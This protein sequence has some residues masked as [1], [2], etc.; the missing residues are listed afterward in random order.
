MKIPI[1]DYSKMYGIKKTPISPTKKKFL[2]LM[3]AEKQWKPQIDDLELHVK[4]ISALEN[5]TL[6]EIMGYQKGYFHNGLEPS[7]A[8]QDARRIGL[9]GS[10]LSLE[11]A[12]KKRLD[13]SIRHTAK[14]SGDLSM[15]NSMSSVK[16]ALASAPLS[17]KSPEKN[18][19]K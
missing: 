8:F 19:T 6:D 13:E 18:D 7:H 11:K 5:L 2:R 14:N 16:F 3:N 4:R 17:Q 1:K 12:M 10:I 9:R 15:C